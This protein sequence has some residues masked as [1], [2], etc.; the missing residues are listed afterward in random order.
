MSQQEIKL[1]QVFYSSIFRH[2]LLDTSIGKK[3]IMEFI[4]TGLKNFTELDLE[5]LKRK[6]VKIRKISQVKKSQPEYM[7]IKCSIFDL[8][9]FI[10]SP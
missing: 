4:S 5:D 9:S 2:F 8:P 1:Q 10:Y 6:L 7:T 3:N